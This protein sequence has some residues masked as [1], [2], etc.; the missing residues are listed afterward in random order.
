MNKHFLCQLADAVRMTNNKQY[1]KQLDCSNKQHNI[2]VLRTL[3]G[4]H[5]ETEM[6]RSR[7]LEKLQHIHETLCFKSRTKPPT[8]YRK[9]WSIDLTNKKI[10]SC[11]DC[12]GKFSLEEGSAEL[13]CVN[14]GHIEILDGSAFLM[15]KTY[16][17]HTK[18]KPRMYTFKYR[19]HKLLDNCRYPVKL[20]HHQIDEACCIFEHIQN[21]L[22]KRICYSFVIYKIL[23]QIMT[24][25]PQLRVL[26][27]MQ[28]K[29]PASTYLKHERRWNRLMCANYS[30]S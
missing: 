13:V 30:S 3:Y 25:E 19:P 23:E 8:P 21:R 15:R 26:Q 16:N 20:P 6:H 2:I 10:Q 5:Y 14:C 22:P 4:D 29:I 12:D 28:T 9:M 27:Y 24:E 7:L 1:V 18:T 17:T 11:Q